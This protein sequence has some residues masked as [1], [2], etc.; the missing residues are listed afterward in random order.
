MVNN[1][2]KSVNYPIYFV[3]TELGSS[4]FYND[5]LYKEENQYQENLMLESQSKD[6]ESNKKIDQ[7]GLWSLHFDGDM[8]RVGASACV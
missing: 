2:D 7:E 6:I 8:R 4:M 3:E 1:K 5:E